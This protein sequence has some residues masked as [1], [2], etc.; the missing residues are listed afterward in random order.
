MRKALTL[1]CLSLTVAAPSLTEAASK[2]KEQAVASID[3]QQSEMIEMANQIWAFAETA[4]REVHSAAVLADY[5]EAQGFEVGPDLV[6]HLPLVAGGGGNSAEAQKAIEERAGHGISL[7]ETM[8]PQLV[9][10]RR[11]CFAAR[12]PL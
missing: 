12:C 2:A 11:D 3:N 4:L 5:A 10:N 9:G 1:L 8:I 6:G 7:Q